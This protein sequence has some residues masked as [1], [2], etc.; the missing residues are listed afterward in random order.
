M[1]STRN[2]NSMGSPRDHGNQDE[3]PLKQIDLDG[4]LQKPFDG[5]FLLLGISDLLQLTH[6]RV[7]EGAKNVEAV[8]DRFV[9]SHQPLFTG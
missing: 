4:P 5:Q 7:E 2:A 1:P 9:L 3:F 6:L 8:G